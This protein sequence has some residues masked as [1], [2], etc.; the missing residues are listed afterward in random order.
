MTRL[1]PISATPVREGGNLD[2]GNE[3]GEN[4]LNSRENLK[5]EQTGM[6]SSLFSSQIDANTPGILF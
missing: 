6:D 2:S 5:A 4:E 1:E 3:G